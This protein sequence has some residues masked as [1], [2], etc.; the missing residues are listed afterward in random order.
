MLFRAGGHISPRYCSLSLLVQPLD[1]IPDRRLVQFNLE[2]LPVFREDLGE[3]ALVFHVLFQHAVR[4][5]TFW[6]GLGPSSAERGKGVN[7]VRLGVKVRWNHPGPR[8]LAIGIESG[9]PF[10][11]RLFGLVLLI[12]G[13]GTVKK[14]PRLFRV[15]GDVD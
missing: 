13:H 2:G 3:L 15:F 12:Q 6:H 11:G 1:I 5:V 10:R 9:L 14:R 7:V 8:V 4:L